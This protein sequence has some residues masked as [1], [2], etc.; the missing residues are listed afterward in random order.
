VRL[1]VPQ[2]KQSEANF[3]PHS[4]RY[5]QV[6]H[7]SHPVF[8]SHTQPQQVQCIRK[9]VPKHANI[10]SDRDSYLFGELTA[11]I[12]QLVSLLG[13]GLDYQKLVFNSGQRQ[14]FFSL[15]TK[16]ELGLWPTETS[17][18][19]VMGTPSPLFKQ[20]GHEACYS[21][22]NNNR[23]KTGVIPPLCQTFQGM[24]FN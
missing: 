10:H 9:S 1:A 16:F 24:M 15:T 12:A 17:T 8:I 5:L 2:F 14:K 18:K 13:Y 21:P 3:Q 11:S 20:S 4:I 23:D 19:W 6:R 7:S 22:Q